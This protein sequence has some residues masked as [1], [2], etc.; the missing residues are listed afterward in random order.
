MSG[1]HLDA[2]VQAARDTMAQAQSRTSLDELRARVRDLPPP[3]GFASALQ[4]ARQR[5]APLIAEVKRASPSKG[6]IA[7]DLDPARLARAY[8]HGGA[9]CLSVLTERRFFSGSLDDLQAARA[10]TALPALRKDF[11]VAPYQLYEAR[12][13]SADAVLLIAAAL[14]PGPL[15]ELSQLAQEL[16]LDVLLEVHEQEELVAASLARPA[17]LGINA[18][19]LKTLQVDAGTFAR[20]APLART[21]APLVAE[22]GVKSAADARGLMQAGA[23]ALLVGEALSSAADPAAKA[24]ELVAAVQ[25]AP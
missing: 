16:S 8:Q 12:A 7:L 21:I 25:G 19:N 13:H 5:G 24:R 4:K 2:L 9:A 11:L 17:L 18:R 6:A 20:L 15:C 1:T 22:S 10:A 3:R 23:S 14:E